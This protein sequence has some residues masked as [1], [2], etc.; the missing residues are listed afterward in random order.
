MRANKACIDS[1]AGTTALTGL[2]KCPASG[3]SVGKG[4]IMRGVI[5]IVIW[6]MVLLAA[7]Q[8]QQL[9]LRPISQEPKPPVC[10]QFGK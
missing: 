2:V 1:E 5:G 3:M 4:D 7:H 10:C 6:L 9:R 8:H